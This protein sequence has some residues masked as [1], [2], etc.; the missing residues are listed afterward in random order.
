M[1]TKLSSHLI[2][3]LNESKSNHINEADNTSNGKSKTF[4]G[5]FGSF[6]G[7]FINKPS[8]G[9]GK[10]DPITA[11]LKRQELD[12]ANAAA[13]REKALLDAK[14]NAIAQKLAAKY[15]AKKNKATLANK[16]KID[17]W[18]AKKAKAKAAADYW[19]NNKL[20]RTQAEH[21]AWEKELDKSF[22]DLGSGGYDSDIERFNASTYL[23][24]W[25]EDGT[26]RTSEEIEAC[27]KAAER[28]GDDPNYDPQNDD[29]LTDE[30]ILVYKSLIAKNANWR[31]VAKHT[32]VLN[33][34]AQKHQGEITEAIKDGELNM[35]E[36]LKGIQEEAVKE[37]T[38]KN[39]AEQAEEMAATFKQN[40]DAIIA[41]NQL[42]ADYNKAIDDSS[43]KQDALNKYT[44]PSNDSYFKFDGGSEGTQKPLFNGGTDGVDALV[45]SVMNDKSISKLTGDEKLNAIKKK[46]KESGVPQKCIDKICEGCTSEM[47]KTDSNE[48]PNIFTD[49]IDRL[50]ES[51]FN[52][53]EDGV[54][55][56]LNTAYNKAKNDYEAS[57]RKLDG[58]Y[59]PNKSLEEE[60]NK[61]WLEQQGPDS[62]IAIQVNMVRNPDYEGPN[63]EKGIA[64]EDI[65]NGTYLNEATEQE[66]NNAAKNARKEA[67]KAVAAT[68]ARA[69]HIKQK[70]IEAK[71]AEAEENL[72]QDI[73]DARAAELDKIGEGETICTEEGNNKGKIGFYDE[74]GTFHPKPGVDDVEEANKYIK[75]R[76]RAI[77]L[78]TQ[79]HTAMNITKI[80]NEK[81]SDGK[82]TVT[83]VDDKGVEQTKTMSANEIA[84]EK[85]NA[86]RNSEN[87][88]LS[89]SYKRAAADVIKK[90]ITDGKLDPEKIKAL[91]NED[92]DLYDAVVQLQKDGKLETAYKGLEI[93]NTTWYSLKNAIGDTD[94]STFT[95]TTDTTQTTNTTQNT[96]DENDQEDDDQTDDEDV[97]DEVELEGDD[98]DADA[99]VGDDGKKKLK[100]PSQIYKRRTSKI[101]HKKLKSYCRKDDP[102]VIISKAEYQEKVKAWNDRKNKSKPAKTTTTQNNGG[103]HQRAIGD[104][105]LQSRIDYTNLSNWLFERLLN[106]I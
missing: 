83:Y 1:Y 2:N 32:K 51:D 100:H 61:S 105:D 65:T 44:N 29:S 48:F 55:A 82:Y 103:S 7:K 79:Q 104:P 36:L 62:P 60:P 43:K 87:K 75:D 96:D 81:T 11:E 97:N 18:N 15:E 3:K 71:A 42:K 37:E 57:Q 39:E 73:K 28:A 93:G 78:N 64:Q 85:A 25:H 23:V 94:L 46:L 30:E 27:K 45:R 101:T 35:P 106:S 14:E 72:P 19:K 20:E 77:M 54:N 40:K 4:W 88:S 24:A 98:N 86:I 16:R 34:L 47:F 52:S 26:M 90:C 31:E 49:N 66:I 68:K 22:T 80:S 63:G 59:D 56:S 84:V 13:T 50:E 89:E 6:W 21:D 76:K 91:K 10:D 70:Q 67:D 8:D 17:A 53:I 99:E 69:E 38:T 9:K 95:G 58:M 92:K 41:V 12:A 102:K 5:I 74:N 33:D